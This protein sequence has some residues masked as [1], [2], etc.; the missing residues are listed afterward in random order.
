MKLWIIIIATT[1]LG[2]A[3]HRVTDPGSDPEPPA[4][5][6][7]P[8]PGANPPRAPR[9]WAE[10]RGP[11]RSAALPELAEPGH[12][13][14]EA[15]PSAPEPAGPSPTSE[16]V[17]DGFESLFRAEPVDTTWSRGAADTLG[18]GIG[19][20]L[21]AGSKLGGI[22]CRDTLCRIETSHADPDEFRTYARSAFLDHDKRVS[23]SGFFASIVRAPAGGPLTAVVY[24]TREGKELPGPEAL[25]AAR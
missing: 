11:A 13:A 7:A 12:A 22:E 9:A 3:I 15:P 5:A 16:Q 18:R 24:L 10:V 25:L 8:A 23:S 20:V 21:P 4:A 19:A 17:R 6:P 2:I 14:A 1:A